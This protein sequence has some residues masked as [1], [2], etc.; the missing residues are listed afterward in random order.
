MITILLGRL[1]ELDLITKHRNNGNLF[2]ED[3][4]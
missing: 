2:E 3:I 1:K 4:H